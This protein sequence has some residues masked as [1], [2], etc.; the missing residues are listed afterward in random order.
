MCRLYTG[1]YRELET[2]I[3]ATAKTMLSSIGDMLD[4]TRQRYVTP[5]RGLRI[6]INCFKSQHTQLLC[7]RVVQ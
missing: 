4:K 6:K 2:R 1:L 5:S 7:G 3:E